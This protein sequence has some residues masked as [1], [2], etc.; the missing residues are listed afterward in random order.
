M[1]PTPDAKRPPGFGKQLRKLTGRVAMF[2]WILICVF[3][4]FVAVRSWWRFDSLY[5]ARTFT[6]TSDFTASSSIGVSSAY[7]SIQITKQTPKWIEDDL[8]QISVS[9]RDWNYWVARP[10]TGLEAI[11][12][13]PVYFSV[14]DASPSEF[15]FRL[16]KLPPW[17]SPNFEREQTF[18]WRRYDASK[19]LPLKLQVP[20]DH[21][22]RARRRVSGIELGLPWWLILTILHTP[23]PFI[24]R[25][26]RRRHRKE[27]N[28]CLNCGY[29]L[30][31]S[32]GRCSECGTVI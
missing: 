31:S 7:G 17:L 19:P 9:D 25:A 2:V 24:L 14:P 29:D 1:T 21:N 15:R 18:S 4:W 5:V 20:L 27:N 10:L 12:F 8:A 32:S 26:R 6:D 16:T 13:T 3:C 23:L 11:D 30:R 22:E 28:L